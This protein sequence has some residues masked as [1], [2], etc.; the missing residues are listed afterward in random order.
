MALL[1][2]T[3]RRVEQNTDDEINQQIRRRTEQNVQYY[4][5]HP[6]LINQRLYELDREWDIERVLEA[7][8]ATIA[9]GGLILGLL[10]HRG[11]LALPLLVAG[12]LLQHAIQGWCPPVPF[13]RRR[14]VRTAAEI[15]CERAAL[16]SLRGDF[17]AVERM[18]NTA[19]RANAAFRAATA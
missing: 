4:A 19:E 9:A 2:P 15:A 3:A 8:A 11:F 14:G 1:P 17:A 7:N 10:R 12:F 13:F 6:E 18:P 16:K 5:A